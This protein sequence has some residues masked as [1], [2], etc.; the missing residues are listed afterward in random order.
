[1]AHAHA[2]L[3]SGRGIE[4][5][6]FDCGFDYDHPMRLCEE[7]ATWEPHPLGVDPAEPV[8]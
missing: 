3:E 2:C 4:T 8:L 5:G 1:M 7:C 6:D